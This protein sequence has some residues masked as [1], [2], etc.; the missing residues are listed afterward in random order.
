MGRSCIAR[1]EAQCQV[2]QRVIYLFSAV[3]GR[4]QS[5]SVLLGASGMEFLSSTCVSLTNV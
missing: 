1:R 4:Y 5:D 2:P 3:G